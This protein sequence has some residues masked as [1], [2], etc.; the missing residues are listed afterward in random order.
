MTDQV[1][2]EMVRVTGFEPAVFCS[3]SRRITRLSYTHA[4]RHHS[5]RHLAES[6]TVVRVVVGK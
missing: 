6:I 1:M 5:I 3:Q 2:S 4:A